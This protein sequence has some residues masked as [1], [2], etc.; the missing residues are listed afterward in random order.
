[1]LLAATWGSGQVFLAM[2][3]FFLFILWFWLLLIV[4]GDIFRSADLSGGGKAAW[5][6]FVIIL[7]FLGAFVYIV[8]RGD[9][10][11]EH[12]EAA[13]KAQNDAMTTYVQQAAGSGS[14]A[15]ELSRLADLKAQ[16]V[17]DDA[18]FQRLK[19]KAIGD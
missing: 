6:I 15:E 9:K 8:A 18:E 12:A 19:A 7:P 16:G 11:H 10:M 4:F 14:T 3:E 1:M 17:I 5:T 13:A 2:L